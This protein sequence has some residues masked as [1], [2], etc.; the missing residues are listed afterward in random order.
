VLDEVNHVNRRDGC[1]YELLCCIPI[2][3]NLVSWGIWLNEKVLNKIFTSYIMVNFCKSQL[4]SHST[5]QWL[6][7]CLYHDL[8][9]IRP[10]FPSVVGQGWEV[11]GAEQGLELHQLLSTDLNTH[12]EAQPKPVESPTLTQSRSAYLQLITR[13]TSKSGTA[14]ISGPPDLTDSLST[15]LNC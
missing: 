13:C 1:L 6:F 15:R 10:G 8:G 5:L 4:E 14:K 12:K 3:E 9:K 2:P 11:C 7:L